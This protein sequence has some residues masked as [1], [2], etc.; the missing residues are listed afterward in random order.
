MTGWRKSSA[1]MDGNC[2]VWVDITA[3]HWVSVSDGR[4]DSPILLFTHDDWR[5]FLAGAAAGEI[6]LPAV[7]E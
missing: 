6:D 2:C 4:G 3:P 7:T 5:A 1:S